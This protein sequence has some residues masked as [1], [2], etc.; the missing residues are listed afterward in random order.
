MQCLL[1]GGRFQVD[2]LD[3]N[4]SVQGIVGAAAVNTH[5]VAGG[6]FRCVNRARGFKFDAGGTHFFAAQQ[7]GRAGQVERET[8]DAGA[9]QRLGRR[10][11][12]HGQWTMN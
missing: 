10:D 12:G 7:G 11:L 4:A 1:S 3:A 9:A 8:D 2:G 6:A 5:R